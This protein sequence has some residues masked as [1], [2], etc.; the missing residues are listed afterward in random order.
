MGKQKRNKIKN[1]NP[2]GWSKGDTQKRRRQS[3]LR[4]K[5]GDVLAAAR[6]MQYLANISD[7]GDTQR[8]AAADAKHFRKLYQVKKRR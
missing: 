7:D 2:L 3:V 6:A 8:K 5:K 1:Y 4:A